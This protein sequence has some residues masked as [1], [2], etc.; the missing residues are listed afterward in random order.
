MRRW[1]NQR[2]RRLPPGAR[3]ASRSVVSSRP[4]KTRVDFA[5]FRHANRL[6]RQGRPA[7]RSPLG[8]KLGEGRGGQ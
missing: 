8:H 4:L 6:L 1:R 7:A 5:A 3:A 2:Q